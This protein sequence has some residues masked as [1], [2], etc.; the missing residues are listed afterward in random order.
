M[1]QKTLCRFVPMK[2]LFLYPLPSYL[3]LN[4]S[5]NVCSTTFIFFYST[6]KQPINTFTD[7]NQK[8]QLL[9]LRSLVHGGSAWNAQAKS[10]YYS[11]VFYVAFY[12]SEEEM[13]KDVAWV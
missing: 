4:V 12:F 6:T 7:E 9:S 10:S 3:H 2:V 8:I 5:N 1:Q 13:R 11:L